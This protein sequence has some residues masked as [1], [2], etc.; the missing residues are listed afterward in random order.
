M[1]EILQNKPMLIFGDGS[2]TR[3]FS[4]IGDVAPV[5]AESIEVPGAYNQVFNIGA[6]QPYS[7]NQLA[8]SEAQVMGVEPNT[9]HLPPRHEVIM[10]YFS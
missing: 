3:T 8:Q 5:I 4:Y 2:Q 10:A 6:D 9:V 7:V 1:N